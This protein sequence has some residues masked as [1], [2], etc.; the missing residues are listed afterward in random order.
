[1]TYSVPLDSRRPSEDKFV[2]K[3]MINTRAG[4]ILKLEGRLEQGEAKLTEFRG[5]LDSLSKMQ[6]FLPR[7]QRNTIRAT[8]QKGLKKESKARF[9]TC[10]L[11]TTEYREMSRI[12]NQLIENIGEK[13]PPVSS[14]NP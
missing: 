9:Q 4:V 8:A 5:T 10:N 12:S 3:E 7:R 2:L 6:M 1:M 11:I 13:A 14:R